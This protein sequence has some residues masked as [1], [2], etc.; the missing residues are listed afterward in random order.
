MFLCHNRVGQG[1]EN[2]CRD[3]AILCR[4]TI[5]K[6]RENFYCDRGF[7]GHDRVGHDREEVMRARQTRPGVHEKPWVRATELH[8]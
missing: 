2:L 5:G 1:K 6:G 3:R 7:L 8:T 4:N